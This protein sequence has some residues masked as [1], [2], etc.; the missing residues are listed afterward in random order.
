MA[1]ESAELIENDNF[2]VYDWVLTLLI[3]YLTFSR[4]CPASLILKGCH[5]GRGRRQKV[6]PIGLSSFELGWSSP[7]LEGSHFFGYTA[8]ITGRVMCCICQG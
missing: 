6:C 1:D 2:V 4:S 8:S 3:V 5:G 7:P